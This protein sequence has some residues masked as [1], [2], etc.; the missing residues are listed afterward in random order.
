MFRGYLFLHDNFPYMFRSRSATKVGSYSRLRLRGV[1]TGTDIFVM[2]KDHHKEIYTVEY[3][4]YFIKITLYKPKY[5]FRNK[6]Y[7][8][9]GFTYDFL[10][11]QINNDIL[12]KL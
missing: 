10:F 11:N 9:K 4:S 5:D 8:Y 6:L 3:L 1:I 2:Y 12:E 7:I